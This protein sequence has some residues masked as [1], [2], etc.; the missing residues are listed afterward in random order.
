[1]EPVYRRTENVF[2]VFSPAFCFSTVF[3]LEKIL[4]IPAENSIETDTKVEIKNGLK[5]KFISIRK[6]KK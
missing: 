5:I 3:V 4:K 2:S 1:M 6:R